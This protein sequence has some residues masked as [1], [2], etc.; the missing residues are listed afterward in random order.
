MLVGVPQLLGPLGFQPL[1]GDTS[2]G[3]WISPVLS[4]AWSDALL[5]Q[6]DA[7]VRGHLSYFFRCFIGANGSPR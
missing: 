4:Q 2:A 1:L 6:A 3:L 5:D 7:D